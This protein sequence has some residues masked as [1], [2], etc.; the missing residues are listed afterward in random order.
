MGYGRM[1]GPTD[2]PTDQRTDRRTDTPS[3]RDAWMHL[4]RVLM[5]DKTNTYTVS[6]SWDKMTVSKLQKEITMKNG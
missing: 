4:K 2:G 5:L 6:E 3:Y 1:D